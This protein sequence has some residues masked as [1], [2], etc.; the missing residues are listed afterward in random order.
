[1]RATLVSDDD[2]KRMDKITIIKRNN[3]NVT[4]LGSP[5]ALSNFS[6]IEVD[7]ALT[8]SVSQLF[9]ETNR[10]GPTKNW[11]WKTRDMTSKSAYLANRVGQ[12]PHTK[13]TRY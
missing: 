13:T 7:E 10:R 1:L 11:G 6:D 2:C 5:P 9:L 8:T 12:R 3:N 4:L